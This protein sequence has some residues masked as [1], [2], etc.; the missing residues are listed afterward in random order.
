MCGKIRSFEICEDDAD[1][2]GHQRKKTVEEMKV[3]R[4]VLS[5]NLCPSESAYWSTKHLAVRFP[6]QP[7]IGLPNTWSRKTTYGF[8]F[9]YPP[10]VDGRPF[11]IHSEA[12]ELARGVMWPT[13]QSCRQ[14]AKEAITITVCIVMLQCP[15][16][17][18]SR[19]VY[20]IVAWS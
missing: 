18:H 3:V 13:P 7:H 10:G 9:Y 8:R 1:R 2:T 16:T 17:C 20:N 4:S 12:H 6:G 14:K 19:S 15:D 5:A 11:E